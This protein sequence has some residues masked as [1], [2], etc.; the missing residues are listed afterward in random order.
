LQIYRPFPAKIPKETL[1]AIWK[2]LA[3]EES[4]QFHTT[5]YELAEKL[6]NSTPENLHEALNKDERDEISGK[7]DILLIPTW[8]YL[9]CFFSL[10]SKEKKMGKEKRKE[11]KRKKKEKK[12]KERKEKKGGTK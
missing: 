1:S 11:K 10:R 7:S 4:A 12:R 6:R 9:V 8:F 3:E 2:R 5:N